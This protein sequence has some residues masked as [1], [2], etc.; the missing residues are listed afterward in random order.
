MLDAYKRLEFEFGSSKLNETNEISPREEEIVQNV[1]LQF[2]K[3]TSDDGA[4][5]ITRTR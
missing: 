5:V 2:L 3:T 1:W 4:D